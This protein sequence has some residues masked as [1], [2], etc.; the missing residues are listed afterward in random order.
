[1]SFERNNA[2]TPP[3]WVDRFVEWYCIDTYQDEVLGDLYE[4]FDR[5]VE[6]VGI[7]AA[8]WKC[9]WNALF[10]MR[11]YNLKIIQNSLQFITPSVMWKNYLKISYRHM[12]KNAPYITI[13]IVGLGLALA[14]SIFAYV[15]IEFNLEFNTFFTDTESVYQINTY[16]SE[17][18]GKHEVRA[19]KSLLTIGEKLTQE[20]A[21]VSTSAR[22]FRDGELFSN[23][24]DVFWEEI[25]YID[26]SFLD[27]FQYPLEYGS[28]ETF[29]QSPN[30]V[31][32]SK[33]VATK[34]FGSIPPVG[35]T[36]YINY[37][38]EREVRVASDSV[39]KEMYIDKVGLIVA[40]V[41][42]KIPNNNSFQADIFVH[43]HQLF[44]NKGINP[45]DMDARKPVTF[46]KLEE[47]V[48]PNY[49]EKQ[50]ENYTDSY[51][52]VT[53]RTWTINTMFLVPFK[54]LG[55]NYLKINGRALPMG[56]SALEPI[57]IFCVIAIILV[58]VALF[59]FTNTAMALAQK[60]LKE[61]GV[62][63]VLGSVR[64][65]IV[66]QFLL[67]NLIAC[68][69]A[70][71]LALYFANWIMLWIKQTNPP[72]FELVYSNNLSLIA[73]L[74]LM[75]FSVSFIAGIYPALYVGSM[76]PS[77]IL[78]GNFKL[79][80]A[81]GVT[82]T[83]LALQ[84]TISF[85][86]VFICIMMYQNVAYQNS[87]DKGYDYEDILYVSPPKEYAEAMLREA[88]QIA[89]VETAVL[90][91]NHIRDWTWHRP[92][93][94]DSFELQV[95]HFA[96]K[97]NVL[98][99]YGI[100]FVEGSNFNDSQQEGN[101]ETVIIN[102]ALAN[103]FSESPIGEVVL[104]DSVEKVV[105]GVFQNIITTE[106]DQYE[107]GPS[108]IAIVYDTSD[109][110]KNFLVVKATPNQLF[111]TEVAIKE[112]WQ[113]YIPNRP[114][115]GALQETVSGDS[116]IMGNMFSQLFLFLSILTIT[117]SASGLFALMSL[118]I[119]RRVKEIGIRKVMGANFKQIVVL[120]NTPYLWIVMVAW[121]IG[122]YLGYLIAFN[123]FLSRYKYVVE[124]NYFPF[125]ISLAI[126]ILVAAV[127]MGG[128][129]YS[130]A[131]ANPSNT[132]KTE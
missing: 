119:N 56:H 2:P 116:K 121:V 82:K 37:E 3:K 84:F 61:I 25:N 11:L 46:V 19:G 127:T 109:S 38:K 51:N 45:N 5:N 26:P 106:Y 100:Q 6:E 7:K 78:K 67:E 62:R 8:K 131:N 53:D 34:Y 71:I 76:H 36:V 9:F 81:N 10:F 107:K 32:I 112:L 43:S 33:K 94:T 68:F 69:I 95:N 27:L 91:N 13:N 102:T 44:I 110:P 73:F 20:V 103:K 74:F 28:L 16:H 29:Q 4:L 93:K 50:L 22:F 129:V 18:E 70:L 41:L 98:D 47:G 55:A 54:E 125:L 126:V 39:S 42:D 77:R 80:G 48:L 92:F 75:L 88:Q 30:H 113:K 65:Q 21:G 115:N 130:A 90:S 118:S 87:L 85:I 66:F 114:F 14:V 52:K 35:E 97:S 60:R 128:K 57:I 63:K 24:K 17:N 58:L 59:N 105:V 111:E 12:R 40:G 132:L 64:R 108:P 122:A 15:L 117:L 101:L 89:S 31:L 104:V 23:G 1:M 83:L 79:K 123:A 72:P 124:A 86:A 96:L 49:I 120:I 99:L